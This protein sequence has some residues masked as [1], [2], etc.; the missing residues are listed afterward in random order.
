M[1]KIGSKFMIFN[2]ISSKNLLKSFLLPFFLI[3]NLK[4]SPQH[5]FN[6]A[7]ADDDWEIDG[8][9]YDDDFDDDIQS[10]FL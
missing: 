8:G 10:I 3:L 9:E 6:E 2:E 5:H 4:V 7:A 1:S